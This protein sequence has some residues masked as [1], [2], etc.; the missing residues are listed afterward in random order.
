M[1]QGEVA[2]SCSR[3]GIRE[4]PI[5]MGSGVRFSME[6]SRRAAT[7]EGRSKDS[8]RSRS[9]GSGSGRAVAETGHKRQSDAETGERR[10]RGAHGVEE[11]K[12]K[13]S[14]KKRGCSALL[15]CVAVAVLREWRKSPG[16]GRGQGVN[17]PLYYS[18]LSPR[19]GQRQ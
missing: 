3:T 17:G 19:G 13:L 16:V 4:K 6:V 8:S 2:Q 14:P 18:I 9:R 11:G 7:Q 5:I 10:V 12:G 1:R 15:R